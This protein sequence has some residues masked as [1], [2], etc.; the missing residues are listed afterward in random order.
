MSK[1]EEGSRLTQPLVLSLQSYSPP[2][3]AAVCERTLV[4]FLPVAYRVLSWAPLA[5][6]LVE[7]Q[8]ILNHQVR[9][10]EY[11]ASEPDVYLQAL[12]RRLELAPPVVGLMTGVKMERLVR[13]LGQQAPFTVECFATVGLTNA[14]AVGDPATYDESPGTINLILVIDR[15]LTPAA[16]VEA[17][18]IATEAKVRALYTAGVKSTV[19][20]RYAT[21]T[22]TDCVAIACSP[23]EPAYRY[24]GKHTQL[25]ALLGRVVY[26]AMTEGL[27]RAG[28]VA[29]VVPP[30]SGL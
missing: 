13:H 9:T 4:V 2:W 30:G 3:N 28:A 10:D 1:K 7:A 22:G 16:L 27:Q 20:D 21:G 23:G 26:E 6:G 24:C 29:P 11:P 25:G 5:G 18:A 17:A 15:P 19:S 14:L 8:T 12:A